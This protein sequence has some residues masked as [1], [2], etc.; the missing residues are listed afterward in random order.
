M[1]V[2]AFGEPPRWHDE[3]WLTRHEGA[4]Y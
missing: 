1:T 3:E 2:L 4:G